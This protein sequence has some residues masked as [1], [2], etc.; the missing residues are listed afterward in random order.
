[1]QNQQNQNYQTF[2]QNQQ[3]FQQYQQQTGVMPTPPEVITTKDLLYIKDA[4]N[5]ELTAIKKCHNY[6]QQS[7]DQEV[8]ASLERAS[9][10]HKKH[11]ETLL[12]HLRTS[13]TYM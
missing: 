12:N 11:Y 4:L 9:A 2:N 13:K 6:A 3:Q 10:M 1:M 7:Q 5:W 8:R